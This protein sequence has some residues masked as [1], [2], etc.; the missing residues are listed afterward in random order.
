MLDFG[1]HIW[2]NIPDYALNIVHCTGSESSL[3]QC[4]LAGIANDSCFYFADAG[5]RC[6][7]SNDTDN[8]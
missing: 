5:V 2:P 3:S 7:K 4:S 8:Y 6:G 1:G